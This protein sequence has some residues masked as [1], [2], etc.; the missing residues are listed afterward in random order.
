M[1]VTLKHGRSG[2]RTLQRSKSVKMIPSAAKPT[3]MPMA[4]DG[5]DRPDLYG[6]MGAVRR[7]RA[8]GSHRATGIFGL[9]L[10][11]LGLAHFV[12][13]NLTAPLVPAWLP[14]HT[15]WAYLTGAAQIAAGFGV[16]LGI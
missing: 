7:G 5:G 8:R 10:I 13:L 14:Y 4:G 9:A 16:L 1:L 11:P 2:M 6:R 15:G 3:R 12:Y